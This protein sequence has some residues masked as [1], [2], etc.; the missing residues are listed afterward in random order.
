MFLEKIKSLVDDGWIIEL[1]KTPY[2]YQVTLSKFNQRNH[3]H[4]EDDNLENLITKIKI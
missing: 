1:L 4:F 3:F 2:G